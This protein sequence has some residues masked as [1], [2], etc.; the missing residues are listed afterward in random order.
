MTGTGK[1][2]VALV[3]TILAPTLTAPP[4]RA[5]GDWC[6]QPDSIQKMRRAVDVGIRQQELATR[7]SR[8]PYIAYGADSFRDFYEGM[9][10]V[11]MSNIST[12]AGISETSRG[13]G[14]F[15]CHVTMQLRNGT[16][17][18]FTFSIDDYGRDMPNGVPAIAVREGGR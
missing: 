10:I 6:N 4:A 1:A 9:R 17:G 8:N 2:F 18:R 5:A 7:Y 15:L 13:P 3:V 14:S 12:E 16:G 11:S